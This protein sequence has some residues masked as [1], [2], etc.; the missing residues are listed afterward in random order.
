MGVNKISVTILVVIAIVLVLPIPYINYGISIFIIA[1]LVYELKFRKKD[2]EIKSSETAHL[3]DTQ[4]ISV[5][6]ENMNKREE[7]NSQDDVEDEYSDYEV[8]SDRFVQSKWVDFEKNTVL[9]TLTSIV[10]F[11]FDHFSPQSVVFFM[12]ISNDKHIIYSYKSI[13]DKFINN[14]IEEDYFD[15]YCKDGFSE[16]N[17]GSFENIKVR[18]YKKKGVAKSLMLVPIKGAGYTNAFIT[19][20]SDKNDAFTDS[21]LE[22][23]MSLSEFLGTMLTLS[24]LSKEF[25]INNDH[26]RSRIAINKKLLLADNEE[27]LI[28]IVVKTIS[29]VTDFDRCTVLFF[30]EDNSVDC[31][32]KAVAVSDKVTNNQLQ[33]NSVIRIDNNSIIKAVFEKQCIMEREIRKDEVVISKFEKI[34]SKYL[35]AFPIGDKI[36][37]VVIER[38]DPKPILQRVVREIGEMLIVAS[39][40]LDKIYLIAAQEELAI[41]DGLTGL[42]NHRHFQILL[43]ES[44][45]RAHRVTRVVTSNSVVDSYLEKDVISVV[46]CDIDFFKKL[47]DNYGHRFGDE[48]LKKIASTLESGVREGGDYAA[49]YGG[50]EFILILYNSDT[51]TAMT[52]ADRIRNEISKIQFKTPMGTIINVTMSFGVST[53]DSD[54]KTQEELIQKAD[55]ALYKAKENGRNTVIAY[56]GTHF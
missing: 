11:V 35:T 3:G 37:V 36:G 45:A 9:P 17:N 15:M 16:L 14:S 12:P 51:K 40:S 2:I 13:S 44:I 34:N 21:D 30:G 8:I 6:A 10:N 22:W 53:Y 32:V 25:E 46:L 55:E 23:L 24:Y 56:N 39:K 42:Y 18:Y 31:T 29:A 1:Y 47:N 7:V 4:I 52:T 50:E 26:Y 19:V 41:R 33:Q 5:I 20:D 28:S 38:V 49:R 27:V 54:A 43:K 48:V